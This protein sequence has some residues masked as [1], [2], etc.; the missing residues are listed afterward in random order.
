M[1][2]TTKTRK[3]IGIIVG[4]V[5]AAAVI[6]GIL[7]YFLP[8]WMTPADTYSVKICTSMNLDMRCEK[9]ETKQIVRGTEDDPELCKQHGAAIYESVGGFVG[10][11][12]VGCE[13]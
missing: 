7:A 13:P 4:I 9:Y 10:M 1:V 6:I 12:Y 3:N 11:E 2:T 5:I 8:K